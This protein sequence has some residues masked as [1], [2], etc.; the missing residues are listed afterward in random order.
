MNSLF[1]RIDDE[2]REQLQ[3]IM[4]QRLMRT[5]N[6]ISLPE[7]RFG[8]LTVFPFKDDNYR[9]FGTISSKL[10]FSHPND[11]PR[12]VFDLAALIEETLFL[13]SHKFKKKHVSLQFDNPGQPIRLYGNENQLKQ[14]VINLVANSFD[15]VDELSKLQVL[16]NTASEYA[17]IRV[18]DDGK[19]PD[20]ETLSRMFTPFF[21]IK[22]DKHNLR[23][24]PP[25]AG[26]SG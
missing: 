17:E 21:T 23:Y 8:Q 24:P 20:A 22:H 15:A 6:E 3:S 16:L 26:V 13:L 25:P 9:F 2:I 14:V 18:I 12:E 11:Q 5:W 10:S 7:N 19:G 4:A 1:N